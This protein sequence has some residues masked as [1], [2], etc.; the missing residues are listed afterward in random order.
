MTLQGTLEDLG[1]GE[2]LHVVGAAR[3]SGLLR[4]Q[5]GAT[6][7]QI[8]FREGAA[9]AARAP[10]MPADACELA[11]R[12]GLVDPAA[13]ESVRARA[14]AEGLD[15]GQLAIEQGLFT[16]TQI[17]IALDPLLEREI[18]PLLAARSGT[19]DFAVIDDIGEHAGM[20]S[21]LVLQQGLPPSRLL[22]AVR[23][24]L[25]A[26]GAGQAAPRGQ[27]PA[28]L[29]M[30]EEALSLPGTPIPSAPSAES[31]APIEAPALPHHAA[32]IAAGGPT[33]VAAPAGMASTSAKEDDASAPSRTLL[34][35]LPSG[36]LKQHL[37]SRL[38]RTGL[39]AKALTST[40]D[41]RAAIEAGRTRS[42]TIALCCHADHET[43][44][45]TEALAQLRSLEPG[46][47]AVI[48]V[49]AAWPL[50]R[51]AAVLHRAVSLGAQ[52]IA[53]HGAEGQADVVAADLAE[54]LE[55]LLAPEPASER[56]QPLAEASTEVPE[57]LASPAKERAH[58]DVTSV[59]LLARWLATEGAAAEIVRA[60]LETAS[61]GARGATLMLH[62]EG[63][64]VV[65]GFA[66]SGADEVGRRS[67]GE[68]VPS[69]GLLDRCVSEA[70]ARIGPM[71][72]GP[73]D[74]AWREHLAMPADGEVGLLPLLAGGRC[75]GIL[76]MDG[77]S[78]GARLAP[79][80]RFV[81]DASPSLNEA[82]ARQR[83][84]AD[85]HRQRF[86]T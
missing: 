29:L 22:G 49:D 57:F 4:L 2:I 39:A 50:P 78:L 61:D 34:H 45:G 70:S 38:A 25:S 40:K 82:L 42:E 32:P 44:P 46:A 66:T 76:A 47:P 80:Q 81:E 7:A 79:L 58:A 10:G 53:L 31:R 48:L 36:P 51:Q 65:A 52:V 21:G 27:R 63:A 20:F 8:L 30:S 13:L 26:S 85:W 14:A 5:L 55:L 35:A 15:A 37:L 72:T 56:V 9:V 74:S 84:Q 67:S 75:F 73:E 6:Q 18:R 60:L 68:P 71:P 19:F 28:K 3:R 24:K 17:Q 43:L 77:P 12:A 33:S 54:R 11:Q 16:P 59:S 1:L 69:L 64:L 83:R 41:L 23:P 86:P 62:E